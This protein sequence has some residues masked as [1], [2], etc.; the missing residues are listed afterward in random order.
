[1]MAAMIAA[2]AGRIAW[3]AVSDV[4]FRRDRVR[5]LILLSLAGAA[6]SLGM[7]LLL[8]DSPSWVV[9]G[10]SMLLGLTL[11]GW[12]GVIMVLSAELGGTELAASVVSVVVTAVGVGF[13]AGPVAF[14]YVADHM[15]YFASWMLVLRGSCVSAFGFLHICWV[16]ERHYGERHEEEERFPGAG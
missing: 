8:K 13:F 7:A 11:S 14:G 10:W 5:P 3:G 6:G 15:G 2:T 9:F 16:K 4:I 1:M 12:N